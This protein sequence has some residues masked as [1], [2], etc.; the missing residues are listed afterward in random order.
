MAARASRADRVSFWVSVVTASVMASVLGWQLAETGLAVSTFV[1][2]VV[3]SW[4]GLYLGLNHIYE[5]FRRA[6]QVVDGEQ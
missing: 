5:S 2:A 4:T 3:T 1:F 6:Q